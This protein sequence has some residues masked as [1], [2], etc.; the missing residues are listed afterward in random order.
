METVS[1]IM[2]W[3]GT[4]LGLIGAY[5]LAANTR[6]SDKGW[7]FF[8]AANFAIIGFSIIG[9][10]WGL[11]TQQMGFTGSSILGIYRTRTAANA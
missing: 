8:L 1:A 2:E 11:L 9:N 5:L 7:Y 3:A 4:I 10:H 6:C